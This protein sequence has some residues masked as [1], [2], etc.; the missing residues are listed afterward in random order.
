MDSYKTIIEIGSFS[1]KTIIYSE[2][3]NE[4]SIIGTGNMIIYMDLLFGKGA[5]M[6]GNNNSQYFT[7]ASLN[8]PASAGAE[9]DDGWQH[10]FNINFGYYY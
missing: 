10:R 5:P 1:I 6:I 7:G 9:F 8:G 3:N 4:F 2:F